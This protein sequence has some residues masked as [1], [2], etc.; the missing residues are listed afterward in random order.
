MATIYID[1]VPYEVKD[2]ENLLS[3]C[4]SLGFNIPYF[5]WHPALHSVG[6][7]RLCA[8]KQF[9][10][11]KDTRGMLVMSCITDAADG[12][13]ISIDDPEVRQFRAGV[14]EWLMTNHPHDC[15]V[16]DEGGECHL[17][18]MTVMT[19]HT[20]RRY[21]FKKRTYRNQ[22][23][24]PFLTHEMN[25]C[26]QCYRCVRFY[27]DYAGGR[28]F[29]VFG[30]HNHL[31]F[32][33]AKEGVL[34]NEFSG[35]LVE[36]CP[37]GVFTDKTLQKHYTRKWDLQTAPSICVHC[38]LGCN[39]IPGERYGSLRRIRNRYNF[40]VNGY[41]L[42]DRG[43][44]GYE[45]V[46]SDRR[47]RKPFFK[48]FAQKNDAAKSVQ[49]EDILDHIRQI[50]TGNNNV[51]GIGSPRATLEANFALR[52]FVG[53]ENFY[54]G[55]S[56]TEYK[57]VLS[58]LD[59]QRK[60][61]GYRPSLREVE[62]CDAVLVLGEDVTNV[63]P[64]LALSLR[65]SILQK[66][67]EIASKL[68]IPRWSEGAFRQAIQDE[69][70]P[71]VVIA[72]YQTKL[73]EVA[74]HSWYATP[75]DI[76]RLGFQIAHEVNPA[77]VAVSGLTDKANELAL[78][79]ASVLKEAKRPLI[80][81]G[82]SCGNVSIIQA[83]ANLAAA[84]CDTGREA[85]LFYT[86]LECNSLGLAL[87]GGGNIKECFEKILAETADTLI[88]LEND[89]YRRADEET[90]E[91][92]LQKCKHVIVIDHVWHRTAS[93]SGVVLPA[94]T[95]A[96]TDGSLVNSESRCQ[97]IYKVFSASREVQP[98]WLWLCDIMLALGMGEARNLETIDAI[99]AAIS[100]E[101]PALKGI[102]EIT[103][104]ADFRISGEK[105]PR[106]PHRYSGRT[107]MF[108]NVSVHEPEP[109]KDPQSPLSFSMEGYQGI[110][111]APLVPRFW[112]PGWNSVQALNKFQTEISGPL[113]GG[114]VGKRLIVRAEDHKTVNFTD[115][116]ESFKRR[117]GE[118]FV[119]PCFHIFGSEELSA[120]GTAISERVPKPYVGMNQDDANSLRKKEGDEVALKF[121]TM[122]R[123]LPIRIMP[124]LATGL[125][126]IPVGLPGLEGIIWP[127]WVRILDHIPEKESAGA[128]VAAGPNT[129]K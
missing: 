34:E 40:E 97:R 125:I 128:G 96:E 107:A 100:A 43:R 120:L 63:A 67:L 101:I 5:C 58:I 90:V 129:G 103:P 83:A 26:I 73:D 45:F 47:I 52:S 127:Q 111:P 7:C 86:A 8:V 122:I 12:T 60:M 32:G 76:A 31:Y 10:D 82:T 20:Y 124:T 22:D 65:Q 117:E 91:A 29:N 79:I 61:P 6:S 18:D 36:V 84:L 19:G 42:C 98:S 28:D 114:D 105:I 15:P 11:E 126:A 102:T 13:R 112:A 4:L 44:F 80:I 115:I 57:C 109:S 50:L 51:V 81:S 21:R 35:N 93:E 94:G 104:P 54:I 77:L 55:M 89:L 39:T 85:G 72:P 110:P 27:R 30:M 2:G 33:R 116:P 70:G 71:L 62:V 74:A 37:T 49:K 24:G 14:I 9:R 87:L 1:N 48:R 41:Y 46:N 38:G 68:Q 3:A 78:N 92:V 99:Q 69:K 64:R 59:I 23:L 106:Q 113:M 123:S 17:Q 88:V 25:R 119:V 121:G 53:A 75:D 16:C 56:Y 66:P 95:F 108:A 118:W